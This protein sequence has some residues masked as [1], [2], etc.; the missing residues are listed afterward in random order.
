VLE[1]KPEYSVGVARIDAQH[2]KL[3]QWVN[4]REQAMGQGRGRDVLEK[5]LGGLVAY[6]REHFAA[7]EELMLKTSY[8]ELAQHKAAHDGFIRRTAEFQQR[9]Q[10][11]E[12]GVSVELVSW[13]G[14]WIRNHV[15][16]MDK[17]YA[18]HMAARKVA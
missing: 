13:L 16:G 8:P 2:R 17:R 9:H 18:P 11:G 14:D 10:A 5:V 4:E 6:T 15:L 12:L 3:F 1:F 7:E